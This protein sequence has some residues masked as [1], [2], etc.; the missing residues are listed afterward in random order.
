[1]TKKSTIDEDTLRTMSALVRMPPKSHEEMKLG[2][3]RWKAKKDSIK[4]KG[5]SQLMPSGRRPCLIWWVLLGPLLID[6]IQ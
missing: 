4:K 1:M 2:K 3:P 6:K 5:K